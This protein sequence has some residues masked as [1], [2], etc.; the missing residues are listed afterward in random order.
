MT[1]DNKRQHLEFIQNNIARMN[2]ASFQVKGMAI[3]ILTALLAA[4]VAVPINNSVGNSTFLFIAIVPT[5]IFWILDTCYLQ[6]ERKFR[7]IYEDAIKIQSG[8]AL[9]DMPLDKYTKGKY[10]FFRCMFTRTEWILYLPV[11]VGLALL[12]FLL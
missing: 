10:G 4:Y 1:D 7:G 9:Y 12:G 11:I 8:I 6:Q 2:Q 5:L 3:A